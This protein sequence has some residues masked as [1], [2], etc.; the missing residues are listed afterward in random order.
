MTAIDDRSASLTQ[1]AA[2]AIP[3]LVALAGAILMALPVRLAGG[4]VPTPAIPILVIFYFAIRNPALL[5][6]PA[7]FVVGLV[8]DLLT[9]GP[10]GVWALSYLAALYAVRDQREFFLGRDRAMMWLGAALASTVSGLT[11]WAMSSILSAQFAPPG[12]VAYQMAITA[13]LYPLAAL[14]FGAIERRLPGLR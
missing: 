10:L 8:Q 5:R 11:L 12:P 4:A 9:G 3:A 2:A 1:A 14:A 6:S 13:L 7:I